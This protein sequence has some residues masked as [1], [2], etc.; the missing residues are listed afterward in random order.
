MV[1]DLH[2]RLQVETQFDTSASVAAVGVVVVVV[3]VVVAASTN[4]G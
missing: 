4:N 1:S 3:V 2:F